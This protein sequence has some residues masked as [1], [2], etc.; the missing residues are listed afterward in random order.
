M[1]K[2]SA[3]EYGSLSKTLHWLMAAIILTLFFV[4]LYMADLPRETAAEKQYAFQFFNLHK[5]FG[6]VIL[7][8][9]ALRLL[10]VRI[11][12]APTLPS[13]FAPK[14]QMVVKALQSLLYL[15]MIVVPLSGYLMS[16]SAGYPIS[17][18]GL[19]DMPALMGKSEGIH[20]LTE[21]GH[22]IMAWAI[23]ALIALHMAGAIKHRLK[24]K[25]GETDILK[26]ML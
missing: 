6:V 17:F 10:W 14:E 3:T 25:G 18:F 16:N 22:E 23:L 24:D 21:E 13:A 11:T 20:E 9:L 7:G 26:R 8:L 5:S 4:G 15:L 19:F 1:L 12:P 2:N